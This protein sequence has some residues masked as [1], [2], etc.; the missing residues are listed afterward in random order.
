MLKVSASFEHACLQPLTKV[1]DSP[2]PGFRG[3]SFQIIPS[4]VRCS[5]IVD[6][7]L[8]SSFCLRDCKIVMLT[9]YVTNLIPKFVVDA[10]SLMPWF[11]LSTGW[12]S[13]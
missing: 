1:L 9:T 11:Y 10:T 6:G 4:L 13:S 2:C 3:R 7:L 12:R 8:S 5:S